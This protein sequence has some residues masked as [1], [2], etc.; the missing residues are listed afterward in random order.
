MSGDLN[1]AS[2]IGRLGKAPEVRNTQS[3]TKVVSLSVATSKTWNDKLSGERIERTEWHRVIIMNARLADV[4]EKYLQKGS[5]VYLEGELQT[6]K[7]TDQHG[8][9]RFTTEIVIGNFDAKLLLLDRR[10]ANDEG[11]SSADN[12]ARGH[13]PPPGRQPQQVSQQR[14][15]AAVS[16]EGWNTQGSGWRDDDDAP[17]F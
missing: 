17:P 12:P 3:G 16:G 15:P 8:V 11:T 13:L 7:F 4:A 6:R 14:Q 1:C 10:P 5:R 2:I 9:E